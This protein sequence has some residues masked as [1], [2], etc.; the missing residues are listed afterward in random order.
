MATHILLI[1]HGDT[2]ASKDGRFTG[3]NDV[4]L[5]KEGRIHASEL[6]VRLARYTIFGR[7][8]ASRARM[9]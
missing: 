5:S 1:R 7:Q 9:C 2:A 6:S 4:S 8:E 3:A